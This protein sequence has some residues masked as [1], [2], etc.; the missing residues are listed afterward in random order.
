MKPKALLEKR[1]YEVGDAI[2]QVHATMRHARVPLAK[3][4]RDFHR[5]S[6]RLKPAVDKY[7]RLAEKHGHE[8]DTWNVPETKDLLECLLSCFDEQRQ[9]L[10]AIRAQVM[11]RHQ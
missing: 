3:V 10:F 11:S 5:E 6:K 2:S 7:N 8:L 4:V 9:K 1:S